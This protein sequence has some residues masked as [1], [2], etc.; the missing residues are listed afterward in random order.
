V[1]TVSALKQAIADA[2]DIT[3]E[4]MYVSAWDVTVGIRSM[5]GNARANL[6]ENFTDENGRMSFR[7]LYPELLIQC[8]FDP[9]TGEPVFDD[10][11]EDRQL[12]LSKSGAVLEE[13]AKKAMEMSGL[14]AKAEERVGKS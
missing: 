10:T 14:D 9:N 3:S 2:N 1:T 12:I 7:R 5:D 11:E 8:V 6:V 4:E 13:V